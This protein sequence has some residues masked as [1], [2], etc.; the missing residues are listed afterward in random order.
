M[1]PDTE[2]SSLLT[3][4]EIFLTWLIRFITY[5]IW[6][7]TENEMSGLKQLYINLIKTLILAVRAFIQDS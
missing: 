7:I 3:R 2:Q 4:I 6:R 5:D 1:R